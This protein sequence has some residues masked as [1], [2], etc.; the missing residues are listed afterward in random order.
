MKIGFACMRYPQP[1]EF[2]IKGTTLTYIS[3]LSKREATKKLIDL[4]TINGEHIYNLV[5]SV[6]SEPEIF[7][8][9]RI[10]S[11]VWPM[12]DLKKYTG[13]DTSESEHWLRKAKSVAKKNNVRLSFHPDQFNAL[14]STKKEVVEN[15]IVNLDVHGKIAKLLG[16]TEI[17]IH[18]WG[19]GGVTAFVENAKYLSSSTQKRLTVENDEFG[20][21]LYPLENI[22][23]P[24]VLDVHHY[25]VN[26]GTWPTDKEFKFVL[27]S[28]NRKPKLHYSYP[29]NCTLKK[30]WPVF[31]GS[32]TKLRMHS[33]T[34]NNKTVNDWILSKAQQFG[35]DI[36]CEAKHKDVARYQL[37]KYL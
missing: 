11:N 10:G 22:G 13:Y 34:Y 26:T 14:A 5:C 17:N 29:K 8:M 21:G 35:F 36:M 16:A 27:P 24:I 1:E 23:F 25:F 4:A 28:W 37:F 15:T 2:A 9:V 6:A 31:E 3:K 7:R 30:G 18:C 12:Y 33:D 19:K 20:V 32:R